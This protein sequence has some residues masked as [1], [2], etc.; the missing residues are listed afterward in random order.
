MNSGTSPVESHHSLLHRAGEQNQNP[1]RTYRERKGS[2]ERETQRPR[3]RAL[4]RSQQWR[5]SSFF[6]FSLSLSHPLKYGDAFCCSA[7]TPN[8]APPTDLN[9]CSV[10][11]QDG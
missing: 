6:L 2:L 3:A 1:R 11:G 7:G 8:S 5:G 9:R 4:P 10:T